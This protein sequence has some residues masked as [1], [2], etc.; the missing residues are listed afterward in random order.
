[1]IWTN[2]RCMWYYSW[3]L[4]VGKMSTGRGG[5]TRWSDL[6]DSGALTVANG[7]ATA[8]ATTVKAMTAYQNVVL[9]HMM[10]LGVWDGMVDI[11]RSCGRQ[12]LINN[13]FLVLGTRNSRRSDTLCRYGRVPDRL[14]RPVPTA[15]APPP[16]P[17]PPLQ[18]TAERTSITRRVCCLLFC[19]CCC[20]CCWYLHNYYY[21]NCIIIVNSLGGVRLVLEISTTEPRTVQP[22]R[23]SRLHV[24]FVQ[25]AAGAV[26]RHIVF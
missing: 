23:Q 18:Q 11:L 3:G 20:C 22:N 6:P 2:P 8:D 5:K 15:A 16:P 1:M 4:G 10:S 7:P 13:V 25:Y 14:Y 19:Y 9:A 17:S 26:L 24:V 21:N 12:L